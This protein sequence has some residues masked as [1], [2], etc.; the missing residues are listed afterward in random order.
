MGFLLFFFSICVIDNFT[1]GYGDIRAHQAAHG[2]KNAVFGSGLAGGEIPFVVYLSRYFQYLLGAYGHAQSAPLASIA[3][4]LVLVGH[5]LCPSCL[6]GFTAL[7]LI[8][9]LNDP[10]EALAPMVI[11]LFSST[12][13]PARFTHVRKQSRMSL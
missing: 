9:H 1:D 3:V 2:T 8:D 7:R 10:A 5:G 4:N 11:A 6:A 12:L 13:P